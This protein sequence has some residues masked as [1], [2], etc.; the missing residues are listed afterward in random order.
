MGLRGLA[1]VFSSSNVGLRDSMNF[2][3]LLAANLLHRLKGCG[4]AVAIGNNP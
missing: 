1:A 4:L 3:K 2:G